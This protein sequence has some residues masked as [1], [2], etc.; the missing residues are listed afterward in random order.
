MK[1][2]HNLGPP[3]IE[4]NDV[5][6]L[7]TKSINLYHSV[8]HIIRVNPEWGVEGRAKNF[9]LKEPSLPC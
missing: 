4:F 2:A 8:G 6:D 7:H 1:T 5:I 3:P 9:L